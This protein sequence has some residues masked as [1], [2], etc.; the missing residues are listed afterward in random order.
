MKTGALYV[1]VSTDDQVEYSPDAQIRL[2]LEY[3]KKNNIIIPKQFIFQDD[4]FQAEKQLTD[5]LFR[6]S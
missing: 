1:R 3:A 6:N 2:G 4:A 5:L